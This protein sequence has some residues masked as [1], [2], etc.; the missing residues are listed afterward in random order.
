MPQR[1]WNS[2]ASTPLTRFVSNYFLQVRDI[3]CAGGW[4]PV[5]NHQPACEG[6]RY[7]EDSWYEGWCFVT[8]CL[9][10]LLS[11]CLSPYLSGSRGCSATCWE[12]ERRVPE[13]ADLGSKQAENFYRGDNRFKNCAIR[14]LYNLY[15]I[16]GSIVAILS[17]LNNV[18]YS[19]DPDNIPLTDI[20]AAAGSYF[21]QSLP[22]S[23]AKSHH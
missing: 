1:L 13:D 3:A 17:S 2:T 16:P 5:H 8:L 21:A 11:L 19:G 9:C 18:L 15:A 14:K 10:L 12:H 7:W 4:N 20:E 23:T 22:W 6:R